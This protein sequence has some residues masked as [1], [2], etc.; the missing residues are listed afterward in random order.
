M[1]LNSI[2]VSIIL[3][4]SFNSSGVAKP[5]VVVQIQ[6]QLET[7][8][9][10]FQAWELV[11]KSFNIEKYKK[12][13]FVFYD[14][15]LVYSTSAITIPEGDFINGPSLF[16]N[17]LQW[18]KKV[19]SGKIM[20]PDSSIVPVDMMSFASIT[21]S[22][23]RFFVMPLP[24]FWEK[25]GISSTTISL[26]HL[27]TGI[28]LH[29][30]SHSQIAGA[31]NDRLNELEKKMNASVL[32][33]DNILQDY[34]A[35]NDHYIKDFRMETMN[36]YNAAFSDNPVAKKQALR[37]GINL[38]NKRHAQYFETDS[39]ASLQEADRLFLTLEGL[40]Q[41]TMLTWLTHPEGAGYTI[42]DAMPDVRRGGKQWS[43]EEGLALCM[44]TA[45]YYDKRNFGKLFFESSINNC[46]DLLSKEIAY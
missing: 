46:V 43:Q 42:T 1:S 12:T 2:F 11:S 40:G 30:F 21:P 31:F 5:T 18:K 39:L 41:Y 45:D 28:F 27:L 37:I 7:V 4:F 14:D 26:D 32:F 33:S 44:L 15:S 3:L 17:R 35:G 13:E 29:E 36:F 24:V 19:H 10:W 23:T 16:N 6:Q 38:L 20:L 8:Q 34:F 22:G 9:H 25:S